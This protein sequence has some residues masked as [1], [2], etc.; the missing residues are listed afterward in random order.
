MK[1]E[2]IVSKV[3]KIYGGKGLCSNAY[4][5]DVVEPTLIDLGSFENV[6]D[7]LK[8]L[9]GLGYKAKDIVNVVFTHLHPDHV[10]QPSKFENA[11]FFASKEEIDVFNKNPEGATIFDG[12]IKELKKIKIKPLSEEIAGMKVLKTPGHTIGSVC[13]WLP[14]QKVLFSGD[15]FFGNGVYGRVDLVTSVPEKMQSSLELL[16]SLKY[17][18]LCPGH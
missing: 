2:K 13:L 1:S 15:T 4:L 11:K 17:K 8:V 9:E 14:E 10:G 6:K 16:E 18:V 5:V 3:W 7:L 12:A